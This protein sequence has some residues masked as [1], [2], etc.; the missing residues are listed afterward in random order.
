VTKTNS[1][2]ESIILNHRWADVDLIPDKTHG[3]EKLIMINLPPTL[4]GR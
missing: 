3:H 4:V 1:N 2:Y